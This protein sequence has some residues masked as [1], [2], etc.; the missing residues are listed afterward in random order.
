MKYVILTILSTLLSLGAL[1]QKGQQSVGAQLNYGTKTANYG[2]GVKYQYN[3]TDN[4]RL[5]GTADQF[6]ENN[7]CELWALSANAHYLFPLQERLKIYPLA[8]VVLG[9]FTDDLFVDTRLGINIGGGIQYDLNSHWALTGD[10]KAH[11]IKDFYQAAFGAGII[12]KF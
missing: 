12:Y 4:I 10:L 11:L 2:V 3:L 6:F 8:G 9:H 7:G 5:E 1:A